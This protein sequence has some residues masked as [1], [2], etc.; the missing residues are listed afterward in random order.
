MGLS[1]GAVP[2]HPV[3]PARGHLAQG[4]PGKIPNA[5]LVL[6][7]AKRDRAHRHRATGSDRTVVAARGLSCATVSV[8]PTCA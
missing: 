6:R 2:A 8:P 3:K 4:P 1:V 7:P 5:H